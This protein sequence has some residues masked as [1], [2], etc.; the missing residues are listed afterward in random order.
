MHLA[1]LTIFSCAPRRRMAVCATSQARAVTTTT[2]AT[3]SRDSQLPPPRTRSKVY[4]ASGSK[5][6]GS[7][8]PSSTS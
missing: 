3:R 5:A 6:L 1:C 4:R 7:S 8:I 2:H